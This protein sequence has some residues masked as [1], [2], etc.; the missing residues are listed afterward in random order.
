MDAEVLRRDKAALLEDLSSAKDKER[1]IIQLWEEKLQRHETQNHTKLMTL[2]NLKDEELADRSRKYEERIRSLELER[3]KAQEETDAI[4]TKFL[5]EKRHWAES[6]AESDARIHREEES[7]RKDLENQIQNLMRQRDTLQAEAATHL[8]SYTQAIKEHEAELKRMQDQRSSLS[9][10][11]SDLKAREAHY[12][13]D[14]AQLRGRLEDA[15][16]EIKVFDGLVA[17]LQADIQR[18]RDLAEKERRERRAE[19]EKLTQQCGSRDATITRLKN[20]IRRRDE[21]MEASEEENILR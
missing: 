20:E 14:L 15:R 2:Q 3:T 1:T 11:F 4:R 16:R 21:E 6:L 10:E 19:V 5:N 7:K 18:E 12:Q 13:A 9:Q 8:H 17:G